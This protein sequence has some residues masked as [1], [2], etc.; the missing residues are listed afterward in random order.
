[1]KNSRKAKEK[2]DKKFNGTREEFLIAATKILNEKVFKPAG[3]PLELDKVKLTCGFP[4]VKGTGARKRPIAECW[5]RCASDAGVNEIFISPLLKKETAVLGTLTHELVHAY[6]DCKNSHN[7]TFAKIANA[8]G[9]V[10]KPTECGCEDGTPLHEEIER[11]VAT[12]GVY[13]HATLNVRGKKK[14]STRM[15]KVECECG[16]KVRL[17]RKAIDGICETNFCCWHCGDTD[18]QID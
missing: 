12:I 18:L 9:L 7:K 10:G 16:F 5:P 11:I 4:S 3:Y 14:Q 8:V 13:P 17:S 15:L 6:D 2:K 1:M